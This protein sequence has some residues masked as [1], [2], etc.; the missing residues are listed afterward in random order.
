MDGLGAVEGLF[1]MFQNG[2]TV[3]GIVAILR[4][5][6]TLSLLSVLY[7][8]INRVGG[9][10]MIR[11]FN[12]RIEP[13]AELGMQMNDGSTYVAKVLKVGWFRVFLLDSETGGLMDPTTNGFNSDTKH[14]LPTSSGSAGKFIEKTAADFGM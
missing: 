13:G 9:S 5:F 7:T 10:L 6:I 1:G 8:V 11:L 12:K 3:D 2:F 4:I 14:Y